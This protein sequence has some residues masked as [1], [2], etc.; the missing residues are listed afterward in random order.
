MLS[1]WQDLMY[2]P[3]SAAMDIKTKEKYCT[4]HKIAMAVKKKTP[5]QD[6]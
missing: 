5:R 2:R 6:S 4:E 3:H 1:F